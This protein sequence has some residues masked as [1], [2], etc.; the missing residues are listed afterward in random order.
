[1]SLRLD[2]LSPLPPVRSGISD[3]SVDL[4]PHLAARADVRVLRLPGQEVDAGLVERWNPAPA[5]EAGAGGRLPIYHM[6]NNRFHEAVWRLALE[7]PG[8]MVLH[9]LVLHHFLLDRTVGRGDYPAYAEQLERDHGWIGA[10]AA[11][12]VY[13]GAFGNSSQF[14]LPAHRTL[15]RRQ[16]GVIV[17]G[18]W[19][20]GVLAEDDPQLAVRVVPM[21]IPLPA[22]AS[23]ERGDD[24]RRRH[25]IPAAAPLLG[26]FGFQTPIKRTDVAIRALAHA[27]LEDVHLLIAGELSPYAS[28]GELAAE[29]GVAERVHVTGFLPFDEMEAAIAATDLCL[30]LRYPT[31]GETSASLLRILAVGRPVIVSDYAEFGALPDAIALHVPLGAD[32]DEQLAR[33]LAARLHRDRDSLRRMGEAARRYVACRH[34][35]G[36]CA[37]AIVAAIAELARCE[38]PG[39]RVPVPP[40]I[41]TALYPR[42]RGELRVEGFRGWR[43]GERRQL[44][45]VVRNTS[46]YRWLPSHVAPGGVMFEVQ[47]WEAGRDLWS[48]R[49]WL[50]L[51]A[52]LDP[53]EERRWTIEIRRPRAGSRFLVKPKIQLETGQV[54]F[55]RWEVEIGMSGADPGE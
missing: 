21:A 13:W 28:Y 54:A 38:P 11:R 18:G 3:Y 15:L 42:E 2:Y 40:P 35:P 44:E 16:R 26:S 43:R 36:T 19:A 1:M 27:G 55:G 8:V 48:S 17:H 50:G 32:E 9:D 37:T 33:L 31:A 51:P 30:N 24:F 7:R 29:V 20:A 39:D 47:L 53:G 46:R 41:T 4:L 25:G 52:P 45:I 14:H 6:G 23:S 10:A 12:P 22:A 34:D 49:P 5:D